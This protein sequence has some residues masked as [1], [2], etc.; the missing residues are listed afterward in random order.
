[1][2]PMWGVRLGTWNCDYD[3]A[4]AIYKFLLSHKRK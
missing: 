4:V 3:G 1:L 2:D